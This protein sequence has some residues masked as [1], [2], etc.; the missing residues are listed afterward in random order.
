M[1]SRYNFVPNGLHS[2]FPFKK[3]EKTS[4]VVLRGNL[5]SAHSES[6]PGQGF[7]IDRRQLEMSVVQILILK[8]TFV[9]VFIEFYFLSFSFHR[10]SSG[11][12]RMIFRI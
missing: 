7:L 1:G 8:E 4:K 9:S 6:W 12:L 2:E 5:V 10:S 3:E 11:I